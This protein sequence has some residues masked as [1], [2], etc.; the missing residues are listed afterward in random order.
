MKKIILAFALGLFVVSC[1]DDDSNDNTPT[2]TTSAY[3]PMDAG[4][5]W[6]YEVESSVVNADGRDSLYVANDTVIGN[7]TYNKLKTLSLP[8]GFFASAL[9]NNGVRAADGKL[10]LSGSSTVNFTEELPFSLAVT[11]FVFFDE[12]AGNN[13]VIDTESGTIQQEIMGYDIEINYEL[14]SRAKNSI[15]SYTA[16]DQVYTNVKPVEMTLNIEVIAMVVIDGLPNPVPFTLINPSDVVVSTQYYAEN[17]GV[18]HVV[19]DFNYE[20]EETPGFEVPMPA[21]G[22]EHQEEFLVQYNVE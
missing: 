11:D 18:V 22:T 1:S 16:G 6:V 12:N 10:L 7:K 9:R 21:T 14:T 4:N 13:E 2:V 19:T 3:L 17:I 20:L 5:Y 15:A 8:T